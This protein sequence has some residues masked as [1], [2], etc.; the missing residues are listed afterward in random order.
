[1]AE[2]PAMFADLVRMEENVDHYS[3]QTPS[4]DQ[5]ASSKRELDRLGV[6]LECVQQA[7]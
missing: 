2:P 3:D 4:S 5:F 7:S 1:M 6:L